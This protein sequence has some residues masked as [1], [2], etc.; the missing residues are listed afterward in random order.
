M[1]RNKRLRPWLL[2]LAVPGLLAMSGAAAA[3]S[4]HFRYQNLE[5][6]RLDAA[7]VFRMRKAIPEH[8][9]KALNPLIGK[10]YYSEPLFLQALSDQLGGA[11]VAQHQARLVEKARQPVESL[12]IDVINDD[13][14]HVAFASYPD[15][16]ALP[17][18]ELIDL[19][20]LARKASVVNT[21]QGF[22]TASLQ[23]TVAP[24]SL[25]LTVTSKRHGQLSEICPG[26]GH[27]FSLD[28]PGDYQLNGLGQEFHDPGVLNANWLGHKR[29]GGNKMEGFQ[30]GGTGNTQFP[31]LYALNPQQ[32]NYAVYLDTVYSAEWDF[33]RAPWQVAQLEDDPKFLFIAGEDLPDLRQ[34]YMALVGNPLVPPRKL[35]GL[36]LS[37]YGFD[38]WQE[39]DDKLT[40]LAEHKFPLDGVVMDLQWFGNVDAFSSTSAMGTLTWDEAHF[41]NPAQKIQQLKEQGVGMML[42][43]ESYVSDGLAEHTKLAED[44]YLV[45]DRQSGQP[46]DSDPNGYG[47][48][49]GKG[50]MIDWTHP[51]A[52][53]AW[54]D[55]KRQPLIEMGILGHWT[56]LGEPEMYNPQGIYAGGKSHNA[57]H[58]IF[59]YKWLES[60][61]AG[62]QRNEVETRPFMMSRSGAPGIQRFGA[63]MWSADIGT[64]VESLATQFSMQPN[65][66]LSGMDYYSSDIGGFHR[67][68]L[69][70]VP[71]KRKQ[72][73]DETYTQWF[74][75]S[76]LFEV[77]VRP[78]TENLCN[79][80]ET[81]PD[82]VGDQASNLASIQLRYQLIP[83]LYSLAHRAHVAAEPVYPSLEYYFG[84]DQQAYNLPAQ[85][86]MGPSLMG[87]AVAKL[88]QQ[89]VDVYL[90]RGTWYDYRTG[91]AIESQGQWLSSVPLYQDQVM[92]LPLYAREG[93]I[94]PV[95]PQQSMPMSSEVPEALAARIYGKSGAFTLY[96]DDGQT[97]AY[98]QGK[99]RKTTLSTRETTNGV[100][101]QVTTEGSYDGALQQR[102]IQ[103]AWFG[104]T[105]K[106]AAVTLNGKPV[107]EWTQQGEQVRISNPAVDVRQP[108]EI[109]IR[110]E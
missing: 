77:P 57:V 8:L 84:D 15:N 48:W 98:L 51:E 39:L 46:I 56:D 69:S 60:I 6:Y 32:K 5:S 97:R 82:R 24:E 78:H 12:S 2:G 29:H 61:Y 75:Y 23:V 107:G 11:I 10:T 44:G 35:F 41:P 86:M 106:V 40:T 68:A 31:I 55:W 30:G 102:P 90:P 58:N 50:G 92:T 67:S 43:E 80:K 95:N 76:T 19:N 100:A 59:N 28:S 71:E 93:A 62:Y 81:A 18:T 66:M 16:Q 37:E 33:T 87:A 26:K 47:Y 21:E 54:H 17:T 73:L 88:G 89:S 110:F 52:G 105:Q 64:N 22:S 79:C 45:Q 13:V 4:T 25:C 104:L 36:W 70:V 96:E 91:R 42:I 53:N 109:N 1:T 101:L 7:Q 20:G 103:L 108:L 85:K 27:S 38:N 9:R 3:E 74:A 34:Q 72:A 65:M 99:V 49:W 94:I 14:L 83:Y 63:T